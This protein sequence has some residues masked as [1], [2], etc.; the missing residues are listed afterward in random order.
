MAWK[1]VAGNLVKWDQ[2]KSYEGVYETR[3]HVDAQG[4][5]PENLRHTLVTPDGPVT[6]FG[7]VS[8]NK[9][10]TEDMLGKTVRVTYTGQQMPVKN[11]PGAKVKIFNVDV[12]EEDGNGHGGRDERVPF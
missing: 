10:L 8:L 1:P 2:A 11:S 3:E 5:M 12:W 7:T 6:F 4:S 9:L